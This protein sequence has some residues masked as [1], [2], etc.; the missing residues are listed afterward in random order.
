[1][2]RSSPL[3]SSNAANHLKPY[4]KHIQLVS[5]QGCVSYFAFISEF[6]PLR[7]FDLAGNLS[8][9]HVVYK[10]VSPCCAMA[11]VL[12]AMSWKRSLLFYGCSLHYPHFTTK[13]FLKASCFLYLELGMCPIAILSNI[14]KINRS[15]DKLC[16]AIGWALR[17]KFYTAV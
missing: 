4:Q 10:N 14:I 3:H 8:C 16:P 9:C 6:S 12:H 1:M 5:T 11:A 13:L 15:R 17:S 7:P 2:P